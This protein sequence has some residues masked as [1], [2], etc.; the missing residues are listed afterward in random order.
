MASSFVQ[1]MLQNV[2]VSQDQ[3]DEEERQRTMR[4]DS[5]A[6]RLSQGW[7]TPQRPSQ[8]LPVAASHIPD[9]PAMPQQPAP[10]EGQI[11]EPTL[12]RP[13]TVEPQME[14]S[15]LDAT[16]T[17][18]NNP[19]R[20]T[21]SGRPELHP[22]DYGANPLDSAVAYE[23]AANTAQIHGHGFK[24][25][26]KSGL[27]NAL[28]APPQERA[29]AFVQGAVAPNLI[30]KKLTQAD[31][32]QNLGQQL[33]VAR[34]Q[35]QVA[36][37][38]MVPVQTV[39][40]RTLMIPRARVG[41]WENKQRSLGQ[42]DERNRLS[43]E[44][45][46]ARGTKEHKAQITAEYKAGMLR[47][48]EQLRDAADELGIP[49]ELQPAFIRGEMK[50]NLDQ[51]GNYV[52]TNQQTGDTIPVT[53][54]GAPG[55]PSQP[56][57][58][59]QQTQLEYRKAADARREAGLDRRSAAQ[60][61]GQDRRVSA[62]IQATNDRA[63]EAALRKIEAMGDPNELYG[64]AASLMDQA[65]HMPDNPARDRVMA[66]ARKIFLKAQQT[67]A[68]RKGVEGQPSTLASPAPA[69]DPV[70]RDYADKHFNGDYKKALEY[71]RKTGY[72]Q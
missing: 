64:S 17:R 23:Q 1:R 63:R 55:R 2:A 54:P 72:S 29:A 60:I 19:I 68:A 42:G 34:E 62:V 38:G 65:S 47:T 52:L 22:Y 51:Q 28:S 46:T 71:A 48:P 10:Q 43:N 70:I 15:S 67:D 30:R 14:R 18:F 25:R 24:N 50:Q 44:R 33:G 49:G 61:A 9:L 56:V 20:L 39:D 57:G 26:L 7:G 58:S 32:M 40:G 12:T 69:E 4:P 37:M 53:Q 66:D 16:R 36:N 21:D 13:R 31:A 6:G 3:L 5:F 59:F 11:V 45:I 35:A 41:D 27:L 8:D